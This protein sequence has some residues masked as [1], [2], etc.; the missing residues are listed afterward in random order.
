MWAK[1]SG[2]SRSTMSITRSGPPPRL[3][4]TSSP[5]LPWQPGQ[6]TVTLAPAAPIPLILV[7]GNSDAA[8]RRAA[9]YG[10]G[11]LPSQIGPDTLASGVAKLRRLAADQGRPTPR[12]LVG[13]LTIV[14]DESAAAATRAERASFVANLPGDHGIVP[15]EATAMVT[16]SPAE[17]AE[18]MAAY[19]AAAGADGV[20]FS[21]AT[22][23]DW[24]RQCDLAAEARAVLTG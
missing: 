21:L 11:W 16:R 15:E 22:G 13:G 7:G 17:A 2:A 19:A 9:T 24:A 10:D 8:I 14:E 23:E 12:V 18:R 1:P 3:R 20:S 6:P 5:S 4:P